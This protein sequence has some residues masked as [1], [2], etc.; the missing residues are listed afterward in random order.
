MYA[1]PHADRRSRGRS[2]A[3][4]SGERRGGGPRGVPVSTGRTSLFV[5]PKPFS[6]SEALP[7]AQAPPRA[8]LSLRLP[9]ASDTENCSQ[10][11][12]PH[13]C[14]FPS[15]Q[16]DKYLCRTGA[17]RRHATTAQDAAFARRQWPLGSRGEWGFCISPKYALHCIYGGICREIPNGVFRNRI[18]AVLLGLNHEN[19]QNAAR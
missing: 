18:F 10:R 16:G 13:P 1:S 12:L 3:Q 9:S 8:G 2:A 19:P 7:E 14:G 5:S 17:R 4:S 15:P 11:A 6:K